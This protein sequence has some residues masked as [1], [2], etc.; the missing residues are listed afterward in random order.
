[1]RPTFLELRKTCAKLVETLREAQFNY[2]SRNPN[3]RS[4]PNAWAA[5]RSHTASA[6]STDGKDIWSYSHRI[7]TTLPDGTKVAFPCGYSVT[8]RRHVSGCTRVAQKTLD[9]C[10]TCRHE[11][12]PPPAA[13]EPSTPE[14]WA[15]LSA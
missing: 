10:P 14:E 1:M 4:V 13:L 6:L 2:R 11:D 5:G 7:G 15:T 12:Y 9:H 3:H 8:T